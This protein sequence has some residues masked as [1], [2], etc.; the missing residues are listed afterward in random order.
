[1]LKVVKTK[2]LLLLVIAW[3]IILLLIKAF[4]TSLVSLSILEG[5]KI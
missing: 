4:W 2:I 5:K 3:E 1:M